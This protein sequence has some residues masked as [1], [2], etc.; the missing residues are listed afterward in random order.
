MFRGNLEEM[1]AEIG[2]IVWWKNV[3]D[4]KSFIK[5]NSQQFV[6]IKN[7]QIRTWNKKFV[8]NFNLHFI[9]TNKHWVTRKLLILLREIDKNKEKCKENN[10]YKK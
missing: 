5:N 2:R 4:I 7:N 8:R 1:R 9:K 10:F 6:Y 3:W